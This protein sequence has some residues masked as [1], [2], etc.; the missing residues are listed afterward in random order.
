MATEYKIIGGP[1]KFDLMLGIFDKKELVFKAQEYS[2][3]VL[4]LSVRVRKDRDSWMMKGTS[5][6]VDQHDGPRD[7]VI[8]FSTVDRRGTL[9]EEDAGPKKWSFEDLERMSEAE[10]LKDIA[11]WRKF[12]ANAK[13]GMEQWV[14][15]L[16]SRER[17]MVEAYATR[18]IGFAPRSA[19]AEHDLYLRMKH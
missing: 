12:A 2:F 19:V 9:E 6:R 18:L 4:L 11:G 17:L 8:T 14:S 5:Y 13:R 7:C 15:Q 16:S 1:S 10:L 3:G